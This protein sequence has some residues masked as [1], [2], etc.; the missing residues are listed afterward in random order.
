MPDNPRDPSRRIR[1]ILE[2]ERDGE[3]VKYESP[4]GWPKPCALFDG[5]ARRAI[6]DACG[7]RFRLDAD[8]AAQFWKEVQLTCEITAGLA[9]G[10]RRKK[11]TREEWGH[12]RNIA[13]QLI[14]ALKPILDEFPYTAR[15]EEPINVKFELFQHLISFVWMVDLRL[16]AAALLR[17]RERLMERQTVSRNKRGPRSHHA[18]P[19]FIYRLTYWYAWAF[20]K[21]PTEQ[22][23]GPFARFAIACLERTAGLPETPSR[24]WVRKYLRKHRKG[25]LK[26]GQP[27]WPADW[28]PADR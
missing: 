26:S 25:R 19:A 3:K 16:D 27:I 23:D 28:L 6:L 17:S 11:A 4:A 5:A 15:I 10:D 12:A 9:Q 14:I 18:G 20:G 7:L 2:T 24:E 8:Q 1:L 22:A 21:F 13:R